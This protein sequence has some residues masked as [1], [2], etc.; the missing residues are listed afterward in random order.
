MADIKQK[1]ERVVRVR[2]VRPGALSAGQ[3]QAGEIHVVPEGEAERLVRCK[4]FEI[5]N[6]DED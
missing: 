1:K 6:D 5:V 2:L 3:Y 4:G